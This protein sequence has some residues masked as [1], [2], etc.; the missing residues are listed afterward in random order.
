ME[1]ILAWELGSFGELGALLAL[2][3]FPDRHT[4]PKAGI[5]VGSGAGGAGDGSW[6]FRQ[7]SRPRSR[8]SRG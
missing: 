6:D 2:E 4:V 3:L 7:W 5:V 8:L 1:D